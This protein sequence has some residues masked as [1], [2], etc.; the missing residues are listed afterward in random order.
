[1]AR[2]FLTGATGALGSSILK[3]LL[4]AHD[5]VCLARPQGNLS[6]L[7]RILQI[8]P[9][10]KN[11]MILEGDITQKNCGI[12][13][14]T[15]AALDG[16]I[17]MF[18]HCAASIGFTDEHVATNTNVVGLVN[19]LDMAREL[20]IHDFR[21]VSTAYVAGDSL[22]FNESDLINGQ[23]LRNP[24]ERSKWIGEQ[25]VR[26]WPHGSYSIYRPSILVGREDGSTPTYDG[27]YGFFRPIH[28]VAQA[29]RGYSVRGKALPPDISVESDGSVSFGFAILASFTSRLNL[30]PIDWASEMMFRLLALPSTNQ[31][32]HLTHPNPPMVKDVIEHSL[33][34]LQVKTVRV[35]DTDQ[36][37]Q[38]IVGDHSPLVGKLQNQITSVLKHFVPYVTRQPHFGTE[39]IRTA[40]GNHYEEPRIIDDIFLERLL[41]YAITH[42]WT[43]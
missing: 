42:N 40:L 36:Q 10:A 39:N 24:Y 11:L 30:V 23:V 12:D 29:L 2:I 37:F 27:Y 34:T 17:D 31:T 3:K 25:I 19:A 14:I 5:V 6:A 43:V 41:K 15:R 21:H 20:R 8:A 16:T 35:V 22:E 33:K 38:V 28:G 9:G 32:Y 7:D 1:M 18:V 13:A 26:A 4:T